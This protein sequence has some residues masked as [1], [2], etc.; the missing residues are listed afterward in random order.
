MRDRPGPVMGRVAT[1]FIHSLPR[2][3]PGRRGTALSLYWERM[4]GTASPFSD[5]LPKSLDC[6]SHVARAG[7]Y[8]SRA[9]RMRLRCPREVHRIRIT[10]ITIE[11]IGDECNDQSFA[12][13]GPWQNF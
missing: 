7:L 6:A 5:R 3:L 10:L 2:E 11:A 4:P 1:Q 13:I 9:A 8:W 12:R